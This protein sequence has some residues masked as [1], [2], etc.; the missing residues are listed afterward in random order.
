[1]PEAYIPDDNE[2]SLLLESVDGEKDQNRRALMVDMLGRYRDAK[3]QQ[4]LEPFQPSPAQ[5]QQTRE[6]FEGLYEGLDKVDGVLPA[7]QKDAFN[8][9]VEAS[10]DRDETKAR[11]INQSWVIHRF[12]ELADA[13]DEDWTSVKHRVAQE[14]FGNQAMDIP[15]TALYGQI[16][17]HVKKEKAEREMLTDVLGKVQ[18]EAGKGTGDW[19]AAWKKAA[20]GISSNPAWDSTH[21]DQY[22][23]MAQRVFQQT[24]EKLQPLR[25]AIAA[26]QEFYRLSTQPKV[27]RG[28]DGERTAKTTADWDAQQAQIS[29]ARR[30]FIDELMRLSPGERDMALTFAIGGASDLAPKTMGAEGE[31]QLPAKATERLERAFVEFPQSIARFG[32][33]AAGAM[34]ETSTLARHA[35]FGPEDTPASSLYTQMEA[36]QRLDVARRVDQGLSEAVDPIKA[37]G[38]LAQGVID[39]MGSV[40]YM[41]AAGSPASIPLTL[42]AMAEDNRQKFVD[43]GVPL[44]EAAVLALAA[45]APQVAVE[46]LQ[47]SMVFKGKLPGFEKYLEK[48]VAGKLAL[49]R[50]IAVVAGL[51]TL[52]QNAEEAIQDIT[53]AV[54][55]DIAA[56]L[57]KD[58]PEVKWKQELAQY[59]GERVDT[60][61][62]LLPMVMIGTGTAS[63]KE[64]AFARQYLSNKKILQ[65]AGFTEQ[66]AE[67]ISQVAA[68]G[69]VEQAQTMVEAAW[70]DPQQRPRAD[71]EK[72]N[73]EAA[74][75][76]AA[77]GKFNSE[78]QAQAFD[79]L[80][81]E[82]RASWQEQQSPAGARAVRNEDGTWTVIDGQGNHVDQ[83]STAD[84]ALALVR[85]VDKADSANAEDALNEMISFYENRGRGGKI[86]KTGDIRTLA[87]RIDE[88]QVDEQRATALVNLY[89]ELGKLPAGTTV[90]EARIM[91]ESVRMFNSKEKVF[92][93][94]TRL[95]DGADPLVLV[96][97]EAEAYFKQALDEA[98][99]SLDDVDVWRE[100]IEGKKAQAGLSEKDRRVAATEWFSQYAVAY[101]TGKAQMNEQ[102]IP[103][104]VRRWLDKARRFFAEVMKLGRDLIEK[105]QAGQ[106]PED[107]Q[108]HLARAVGLDDA[109]IERR[110]RDEERRA[111]SKDLEGNYS[112]R[113]ALLEIKLPTPKRDTTEMRGELSNLWESLKFN[114]RMN[115]FAGEDRGLD[116]VAERLRED[117]G[118]S[119]VK[120]PDDV[121]KLAEDAFLRGKDVFSDR[122]E[123]TTFAL[124]KKDQTRDMF[125]SGMAD[126]EFTLFGGTAEDHEGAVDREEARREAKKQ[127]DKAQGEMTFSLAQT[128]TPEFRAWFGDSK[129]VDEQGNPKV[130]YHGTDQN[131]SVPA[132]RRRPGKAQGIWFA[133]NTKVAHPFIGGG[134]HGE[135]RVKQGSNLMP[136]FLSI[137]NPLDVSAN[138]VKADFSLEEMMAKI[139]IPPSEHLTALERMEVVAKPIRDEAFKDSGTD[140]S[141]SWQPW[142]GTTSMGIARTDEEV[143]RHRNALYSWVESEPFQALMRERGYDGVKAREGI[144]Y[145][146]QAASGAKRVFSRNDEI[147]ESVTWLPLSA[148][149]IKSATGNRGTFDASNPDITMALRNSRAQPQDEN[150]PRTELPDG[151]QLIGP[152]TFAIRAYHGTPHKVDKFSTEKIGTGEG[153]Q[154]YGWGL[155]FAQNQD[156]ARQYRESLAGKPQRSN[157]VIDGAELGKFDRS[158]M[159]DDERAGLNELYAQQAWY[160]HSKVDVMNELRTKLPAVLEGHEQTAREYEKRGEKV[161]WQTEDRIREVKAAI[162]LLES[163]RVSFKA[164]EAPG[165][166]YTV[167]LMPDAEELLDWDKSLS[168]QMKG[169]KADALK[170]LIA[171][172]KQRIHERRVSSGWG[173]L[174]KVQF[175]APT[176]EELLEKHTG[177]SLYRMMVGSAPLSVEDA[178]KHASRA[179]ANL[180]ILGIRYLDQGSREPIKSGYIYGTHGRFWVDDG[181]GNVKE[182]P[183]GKTAESRAKAEAEMRAYVKELEAKRTYN[184]VV[185]DDKLVRILEENGRPVNQPEMAESTMALRKAAS[186]ELIAVHNTSAEKLLKMDELG[187]I[188]APSVAV[189]KHGTSQYDSFGDITL[190][191]KKD[192]VDPRKSRTAKAF[193]ADVYSPRF[194]N[195]RYQVDVKELRAAWKKLE[196]QSKALGHVLSSELD[197][198]ELEREGWKAFEDST[199]ALGAYLKARGM[200]ATVQM[201]KAREDLPDVFRQ[202]K[203]SEHAIADDPKF[204]EATKAYFNDQ[205]ARTEKVNPEVA[206]EMR[207]DTF[208]ENGDIHFGRRY[209]LARDVARLNNPEP[210]RFATRLFYRDQIEK[211]DAWK[212]FRMWAKN[213]FSRVFK[214]QVIRDYNERTGNTKNLAYTVDNAVRVMKRELQDGEGFNYGV[215]SIRST[216]AK[217]FKSLAAMKEDANSIVTPE[218]IGAVKEE[219]DKEFSDLVNELAP[220]YR[221]DA[222]AFGYLDQASQSFKE[223]GKYGL[224]K[225]EENFKDTPPELLQRVRDFLEKLRNAPTEY[226]EVKVQRPVMLNEMAGAVIP[227]DTTPEV[228]QVLQKHGI[229]VVEYERGDIA[230]RMSAVQ[231]FGDESWALRTTKQVEDVRE[232]VKPRMI[233]IRVQAASNFNDEVKQI[234]GRP[235]YEVRAMGVNEREAKKIIEQH[236]GDLGKI[237]AVLKDPTQTLHP[238]TKVALAFFTAE[239]ANKAGDY[240]AAAEIAKSAAVEATS[241]GQAVN[242]LKRWSIFSQPETCQQLLQGEIEK[243]N[244]RRRAR[245]PGTQGVVDVYGEI[246]REA[247]KML[248]TWL[249]EING[250]AGKTAEELEPVDVSSLPEVTFAL[251]ADLRESGI[252]QVVARMLKNSGAEATEKA[253]IQKYGHGVEAHIPDL[254]IAAQQSLTTRRAKGDKKFKT[255]IPQLSDEHIER[256][257]GSIR[258][259]QEE[260]TT[261]PTVEE[262][263]QRGMSDEEI[264]ATL[265]EM[266]GRQGTQGELLPGEEKLGQPRLPAAQIESAM[267]EAQGM[268][269][270]QTLADMPELYNRVLEHVFNRIK[271]RVEGER[272]APVPAK[273]KQQIAEVLNQHG[274]QATQED[275]QRIIGARQMLPNM[276]PAQ[277]EELAGF[278]K[279]IASTP[280]DSFERAQQTMALFSYVH[281]QLKP[282]DML[283]VAFGLWYANVLSSLITSARNVAGNASMLFLDQAADTIFRNP[284]SYWPYLQQMWKAVESSAEANVEQGK[285]TLRTGQD[286]LHRNMNMGDER[287][288]GVLESENAPMKGAR[289]VSRIATRFLSVQDLFFATTAYEMKARQIAWDQ[290]RREV[291][292]GALKPEQVE[293]RVALLLN[294]ATDQVQTFEDRARIEWQNLTPEIQAGYD[295]AN[296]VKRRVKELQMFERDKKLVERAL[297]FA[298][299]VTLDFE[300]EGLMGLLLG[301]LSRVF[302]TAEKAAENVKNPIARLLTRA[303]AKYGRTQIIPFMRVPVNVFNRALDYGPVGG[304]RVLMDAAGIPVIV[305]NKTRERT[306][307]EKA[308]LKKRALLGTMALLPLAILARPAGP[309]DEPEENPWLQIH[310]AGSGDPKKNIGLNGPK[311]RPYSIEIN[312]GG[313]KTF[314]DYRMFP[315]APYL[316]AIGALHDRTR[317]AKQLDDKSAL[318]QGWLLA[319][320]MKEGFLSSSPIT[321]LRELSEAAAESQ[322]M[323]ERSLNRMLARGSVGVASNLIPL[324]G[325][326]RSLDQLAGGNRNTADTLLAASMAQIPVA[327]RLNVPSV[328]V[329]GDTMQSRAGVGWVMD[330]ASK[331]TPEA[332]I[333]RAFAEKDVTPTDISKYQHEMTPEEF[334]AFAQKRGQILKDFLLSRDD[335]GKLRI[336]ALEKLSDKQRTKDEPSPAKKYLERFSTSATRRALSAVGYKKPL[337]AV[338]P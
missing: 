73:R 51:E 183:A 203:G 233:G 271:E 322:P 190:I 102:A 22:R 270:E 45:A 246:Q 63:L 123:T 50:K 41:L 79:E 153:A 12:P 252:V 213:N 54:Y 152:S 135:S 333:Y 128:K 184:Y 24:Q 263:K 165:N 167:D 131:F 87:D 335:S 60:F 240:A 293:E 84:E 181:N 162:K 116:D 215:G 172:A 237:M 91:G 279:R 16:G 314:I 232:A 66:T 318:V 223:L 220:Y 296:W 334:Y 140:Y 204:I 266:R 250:V 319:Q 122:N 136:A 218:Q 317:Y 202:F 69:D 338:A 326:W 286:G 55:Q 267:D 97:E 134:R 212:D 249:D 90:K 173:E 100:A 68:K 32:A 98:H 222:K 49:A 214:G 248:R 18:L 145:N 261:L 289:A 144:K 191:A 78:Q 282:Y 31:A 186:G 254:F 255:R 42:G 151:S 219:A 133:E 85:E 294:Q 27:D 178:A 301:N 11:M 77:V 337:P 192:T 95:H 166:L 112:A 115:L 264:E 99:F 64:A 328:D 292:S 132:S 17:A 209:R 119:W 34:A 139:G 281:D 168:E 304:A 105:E 174:E 163:G 260:Q 23:A 137:Q 93:Y 125:D 142:K 26:G 305:G 224:R 37:K 259:K 164:A 124:K 8:A 331:D 143:L 149:Q 200:D 148:G 61:F 110:M 44:Q 324:S 57:S 297:D 316:A 180:G 107:F 208:D 280:L 231:D 4:G 302:S 313:T 38:R 257:L 234:L 185:F 126:E 309:D 13:V 251:R 19:V 29:G 241:A 70:E 265:A 182:F 242:E 89:V 189:I 101:I 25:P 14:V 272:N 127:Q 161:P 283:D 205:I 197:V 176:K 40:P 103:F 198:E 157:V 285:N 171:Q 228:R 111:A 10:T 177:E 225:W 158:G 330:W 244:Q 247:R 104:T 130:V 155:Y 199:V 92:E 129:V 193:N 306:A 284:A 310:G 36:N 59:A 147:A 156:V 327:S 47:A 243:E 256:T 323:S 278:A 273:L 236:G 33:A 65:A 146:E 170:E 274:L 277:A 268:E 245:D 288:Q 88:G 325:L 221:Y 206:Q 300:P 86:E 207:E 238:A 76:V 307:E 179:L 48:A 287:R 188:A 118:F 81:E 276:T 108:T 121:I 291:D 229:P 113:E 226:F 258:G 5:Q 7:E 43:A 216:V 230:Q 94:I 117:Y 211:A 321:S 311:Y 175:I 82:M 28:S 332:R 80:N 83:T 187:G 39:A 308:D 20:S 1:M 239:A 201:E 71:I 58:V 298:Q 329:L 53:P 315:L 299:K 56:T 62:A 312:R 235:E 109:Y 150:A 6:K 290:A 195:T 253:L 320:A 2:A 295:E 159:T 96:E 21:H 194:P 3:Q 262:L 9:A 120:G 35:Y 52:Q 72:E 67:A 75:D 227:K 169:R 269:G 114:E 217:Q 74:K 160:N 141:T 336:E 15:D 138:D 30:A 210:D 106:L 303:A 46:H 154:V 196:E 275:V